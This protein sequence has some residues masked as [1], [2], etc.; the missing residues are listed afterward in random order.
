MN[1][2]LIEKIMKFP[3]REINHPPH[4]HRFASLLAP[5][6]VMSKNNMEN[7]KWLCLHPRSHSKML[8]IAMMEK[9]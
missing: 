6:K 8:R 5:C 2:Q 4:P 1:L 9:T 7:K 3:Y